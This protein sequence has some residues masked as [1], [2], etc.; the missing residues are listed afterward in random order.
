MTAE[1]TPKSIRCDQVVYLRPAAVTAFAQRVRIRVASESS[2]DTG[3]P[4][5]EAI[6]VTPI[7]PNCHIYR[8]REGHC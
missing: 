8:Y 7:G 5:A 2:L 6:G 1:M 4:L 3:Y